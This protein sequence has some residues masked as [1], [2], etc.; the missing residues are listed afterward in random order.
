MP[1]ELTQE[2]I[3]ENLGQDLSSLSNYEVYFNEG[4][5]GEVR[6]YTTETLPQETI[7]RLENEIINQGVILTEPIIHIGRV[8]VI[9]FEKR[10]APLLIIGGIAVA[11]IGG[12]LG[13]QLFMETRLG[14][15]VWAWG[16]GGI[17]LFYLLLKN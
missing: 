2:L 16:V 15:P 10:I 3:A 4:T 12:I 8:I 9:S 11:I 1:Q 5:R 7:E 17:I 14:I 6:L 13:W